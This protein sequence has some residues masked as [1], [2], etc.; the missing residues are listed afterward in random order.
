[1]HKIERSALVKHSA[2]DMFNLVNDVASYPEF[3]KWC[4]SSRVLE[5]SSDEM[6]AELEIAWK[7]LHKVFSTHNTLVEGESI[8]LDITSNT[9]KLKYT[10]E[11]LKGAKVIMVESEYN[12]EYNGRLKRAD[13]VVF[14]RDQSPVFIVECKAPQIKLTEQVLHQIA[15]YNHELRVEYLMM[16]NGMEHIYCHVDQSTGVVQYL[17]KLPNLF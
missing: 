11:D 15:G 8:P 2:L 3:L 9:G 6:K 13:I 5:Q 12:L 1:M 14:G 10:P 16:T 4:R 17:E 7:V